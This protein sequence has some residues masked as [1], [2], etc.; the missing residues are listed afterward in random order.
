MLSTSELNFTEIDQD[1]L[2][3][4]RCDGYRTDLRGTQICSTTFGKELYTVPHFM[5]IRAV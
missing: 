3:S 4:A 1:Y 5:Q 2:P